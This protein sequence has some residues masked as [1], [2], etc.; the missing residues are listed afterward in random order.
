MQWLFNK[1]EKE[2]TNIMEE[3]QYERALSY[4]LLTVSLTTSTF[5]YPA[6][7]FFIYLTEKYC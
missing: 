4:S 5:F 2:I 6:L 7:G 3:S 1:F